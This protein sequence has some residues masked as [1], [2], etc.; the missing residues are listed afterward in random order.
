MVYLAFLVVGLAVG[1]AAAYIITRKSASGVEERVRAEAAAERAAVAAELG[2]AQ[3]RVQEITGELAARDARINQLLSENSAEVARRSTAEEK[4]SRVPA[5]EAEV[6]EFERQLLAHTEA[7]EQKLMRSF[8]KIGELDCKVTELETTLQK[9][10]D[11]AVEKLALVEDARQK[12]ADAFSALSKEAL[13]RNS[14]SFVNYAKSVLDGYQRSAQ[15]DLRQRQSRISEIVEPV[16]QSLAKVDERIQELEKERAGAYGEL[17]EQVTQMA[18]TQQQLRAETSNL[19]KALRSSNTRGQWGEIQLRRVVELAGMT[20]YCDFC[21]QASV[22]TEDGRQRPDMIIKLPSGRTIVVDAKAPMSGFLDAH[23]CD[24][25]EARRGHLVRHAQQL[26]THIGGLSQKAYWNSF[27]HSPEFVVLFLP[28]EALYSAALEH[29]PS[30]IEDGA[31]NNVIVATPTTLIALL[32]A[33]AYG[34]RQEAIAKEVRQ[35]GAIGQK[36]YERL[37]KLSEYIVTL[38][39]LLDKSVGAY[40]AMVGSLERRVLVTAREFKKLNVTADGGDEI[41]E[42]SP[43]ETTARKLDAPELTAATGVLSLA[44]TV[45]VDDDMPPMPE[46]ESV[47]SVRAMA[48]AAEE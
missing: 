6:K 48:A 20:N 45:V 26:R 1:F 41:R 30:L 43:V 42:L 24:D 33:A 5:L 32:K 39:S 29:D 46:I 28:N 36:L 8:E 2:A 7:N 18:L 22:D 12:L 25:D 23:E 10:R 11:A 19:V 34:W 44:E 35:V 4:A 21:E 27:K 38:G 40:N 17:R 31:K 3:R 16:K 13:D 9:E 47:R 37:A 15:E 14:E